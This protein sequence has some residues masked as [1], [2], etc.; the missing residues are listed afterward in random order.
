[1]NIYE[2]NYLY[3]HKYYIHVVFYDNHFINYHIYNTY[4]FLQI[5]SYF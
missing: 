2:L 1:M 3:H 5:I 4:Y